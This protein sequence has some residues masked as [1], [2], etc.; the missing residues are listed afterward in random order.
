[1]ANKPVKKTTDSAHRVDADTYD[2]GII[3][4]ETAARMDR[5]GEHYKHLPT[6]ENLASAP[7]DHQ[8]NVESIR[9]TDGYTMDQEGLLNNYAVEPEMYYDVPG[10]AR[11]D[12]KEDTAERIEELQEVNEDKTGELTEKE[13]RRGKGPGMI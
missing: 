10:D 8:S 12:L 1:M 11:K 7:S 3:P 5:E 6:E 9:T 4:A 13:D 2:R